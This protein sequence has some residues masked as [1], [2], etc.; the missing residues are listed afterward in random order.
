MSDGTVAVLGGHP[1]YIGHVEAFPTTLESARS[2]IGH[3][4]GRC[5]ERA[6][7]LVINLDARKIA[8]FTIRLW[9]DALNRTSPADAP[10]NIRMSAPRGH[11]DYLSRGQW[12]L[13][14]KYLVPPLLKCHAL[15]RFMNV[16]RAPYDD[17]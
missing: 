12:V 2:V 8:G 7:C 3:P 15:E 16:V 1:G 6:G 13:A 4:E 14:K 9:G 17:V 10:A 11:Q 5:S